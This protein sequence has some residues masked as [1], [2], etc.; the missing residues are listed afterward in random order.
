MLRNRLF[1]ACEQ[2]PVPPLDGNN[3]RS[4]ELARALRDLWDVHLLVYVN[5]ASHRDR[6]QE[7]WTDTTATFHFLSKRMRFRYWRSLARGEAMPTVERDF[8]REAA[9]IRTNT[10]NPAFTRLLLDSHCVA[11]LAAHFKSGVVVTGPDCMSRQFDQLMTH[12]NSMKAR[13]HNRVRR[14]FALNNERRWFHLA[15]RTHMVS[16]MDRD[17]LLAS[18][19][20]ARVEV[21]PLGMAMPRAEALL[22]WTERRG[23]VIWGNVDF[24]PVLAGLQTIFNSLNGAETGSL[25]DWTLL[26]KA[27][28]ARARTHLPN[29]DATGVRYLEW[30]PDISKLL[31]ESKYVLCPDTG[32]AGQKNRCLDALAHG[33]VVLGLAE[34]FRGFE[35][36]SGDAYFEMKSFA[37]I[38]SVLK[39]ASGFKGAQVARAGQILVQEQF[40][41]SALA[42]HWNQLLLSLGPL[43]PEL[44]DSN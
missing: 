28:K 3:R 17:A 39:L 33:C 12:S 21:I 27:P 1:I 44:T 43:I 5:D 2:A 7:A 35:G 26:G 10:T 22:P 23:G 16:E 14:W 42:R 19:P 36:K 38:P 37:E 40:S 15:E 41:H 13:L 29:L 6:V 24:P 11:P 34:I 32:G 31:A 18:N 4:Y 25:R 9:I 8:P 30:C 20:A